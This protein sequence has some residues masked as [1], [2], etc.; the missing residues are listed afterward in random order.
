MPSQGFVI[1]SDGTKRYVADKWTYFQEDP[2]SFEAT[3]AAQDEVAAKDRIPKPTCR[4]GMQARNIDTFQYCCI[5]GYVVKS[6][7]AC[8]MSL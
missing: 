6:C 5:D 1:T 7:T 8:N 2:G 4:R 3:L